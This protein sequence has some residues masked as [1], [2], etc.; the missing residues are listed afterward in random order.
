MRERVDLLVVGALQI[1]T[2]TDAGGAARGRRQ[3]SLALI[4]DGAV[5]VRKGLVVA[6]GPGSELRRR[7]SS[8]RTLDAGGRL[9]TPGLVDPHTHVLYAGSRAHEFELRLSGATYEEISRAGGGILSTVE[10]TRGAG[11]PGLIRETLPRLARMLRGGTTSAEV[12][13][14]YALDVRGELA[15]LRAIRRLGS[16]Q[17]L[18]LVSTFLGAHAIPREYSRRRG[19]YVDLLVE[20]AIPRVA[21]ERLA[22]FCDVFCEPGFFTPAESRRILLSARQRGLDSKIHADE[23]V[24]SGGARL[25]SDLGAVSADHLGAITPRDV[26]LLAASPTIAVL[27]PGT[28]Y[29]LRKPHRP[30][31]RALIGAGAAVALGTDCNPGS[32]MCASMPMAMNQACLMLGMT[33]AESLVAGTLNAAYACGLGREAGSLD[34]GKWADLVIWD[35]PDY[36]HIPYEYGSNLVRIVVKR[37][38]VVWRASI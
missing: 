1:A 17:P 4:E 3:G 12:K 32:N 10:A 33:P 26:E 28:L 21:R 31:A 8:R 16:I 20:R 36:R 38:R 18:S 35:C 13:S 37:G 6:V 24:R 30:P 29:F 15:S 11:M 19:R 5:A 2:P 9:V 27:L 25:A 23:F 14:G 22:R 34:P 7:F